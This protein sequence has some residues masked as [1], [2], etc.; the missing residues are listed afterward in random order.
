VAANIAGRACR[1]LAWP[2]PLRVFYPRQEF[3]H[4]DG[5][6]LA[7]AAA[8]LVLVIGLRRRQ[9]LASALLL[10][11][12]LSLLTVLNLLPIGATFAERFLYLP[13]AFACLAA[14]A[15]LAARARAERRSGAGLGV[16]ILLPVLALA[17][18]VPLCRQATA[19][20]HDDLSLWAQAAAVAPEVAHARYNHGYFLDAAGRHVTEDTDRPSAADEL[21]Q[22]LRLDPHHRYAGFAHQL[23][24]NLALQPQSRRLPDPATAAWHY[25]AALQAQPTL[26]EARMNLAALA[27]SAPA[28]VD[29]DEALAVLAGVT[30]SAGASASQ[31]QS[32]QALRLQL[33]LPPPEPAGAPPGAGADGAGGPG[34]ASPT[35]TSSPDGS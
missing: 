16:S 34:P 25:R 22:S 6:W 3:T 33:L 30:V 11:V 12:P 7:A 32:A 10:C 5:A 27:L 13:S 9:P 31:R 28:V 15:L 26:V 8:C 2:H 24:G 20:F 14:G 19:A 29:R 18:C 1:L 4:A 21:S 35:G 23:L 17:A